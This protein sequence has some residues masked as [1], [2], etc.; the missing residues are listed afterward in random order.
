M[1]H[2]VIRVNNPIIFGGSYGSCWVVMVGGVDVASAFAFAGGDVVAS[3]NS[4]D[5]GGAETAWSP[6]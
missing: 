5:M 6:F 1:S 4:P 3:T 2:V